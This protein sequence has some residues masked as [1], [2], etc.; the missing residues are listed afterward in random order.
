LPLFSL[1][2]NWC[3]GMDCEGFDLLSCMTTDDIMT[4]Q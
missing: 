1:S 4:W 2:G 3:M